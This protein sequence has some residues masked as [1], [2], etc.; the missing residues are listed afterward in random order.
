MYLQIELRPASNCL[1]ASIYT[2]SPYAHAY[3]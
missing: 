1:K 2:A 3:E